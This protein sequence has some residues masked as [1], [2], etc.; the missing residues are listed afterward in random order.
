MHQKYFLYFL[1]KKKKSNKYEQ[2][3]NN[4]QIDEFEQ[5]K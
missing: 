1:T 5:Y 3:K 2:T 4:F